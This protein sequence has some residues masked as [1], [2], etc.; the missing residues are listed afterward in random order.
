MAGD[1][2]GPGSP[3]LGHAHQASLRSDG[4]K[5]ADAFSPCCPAFSM[6]HEKGKI[7][8]RNTQSPF[9]VSL[10]RCLLPSR[11]LTVSL[12]CRA[13]FPV[14]FPWRRPDWTSDR[15]AGLEVAAGGQGSRCSD[16]GCK[17]SP[18]QE[19]DSTFRIILPLQSRP[20]L[21]LGYA[22]WKSGA[23][24]SC[25]AA[26][27]PGPWLS[28]P[29]CPGY[30]DPLGPPFLC[31]AGM[32]P[33]PTGRCRARSKESLLWGRAQCTGKT[34]CCWHHTCKGH[35]HKEGEGRRER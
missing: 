27:G 14:R 3:R 5:G 16:P 13:P 31:R 15:P 6:K 22:G 17:I 24:G 4:R 12:L 2:R 30:P 18:Y 20:E 23:G 25:P 35:G 8:N 33:M 29:G 26:G 19:W 11:R 21:V 9:P 32:R 10:A 7:K 28:P 1:A 34:A